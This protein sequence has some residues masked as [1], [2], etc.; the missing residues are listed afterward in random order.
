MTTAG[1][2]GL[3]PQQTRV[4]SNGD[5]YEAG[6]PVYFFNGGRIVNRYDSGGNLLTQ[7]VLPGNEETAGLAVSPDSNYWF[8]GENASGFGY[9]GGR[10]AVSNNW[11]DMYTSDGLR[12]ATIDADPLRRGLR[13]LVRRR[14]GAGQLL[15]RAATSS[16]RARTSFTATPRSIRSTAS[17]TIERLSGSFSWP[18]NPTV[19]TIAATTPVGT[20]QGSQAGRVHRHPEQHVRPPDGLLHGLGHRDPGRLQGKPDLGPLVLGQTSTR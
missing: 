1:L 7:L 20:E 11:I 2:A 17:S 15:R 18:Q 12:V 8:A 19:V 6:N 3:T 14:H 5:V 13:G 16:S 10:S 4:A 9:D